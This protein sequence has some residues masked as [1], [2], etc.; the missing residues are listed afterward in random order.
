[1]NLLMISQDFPPDVGG[2]QTYCYELAGCFASMAPRLAVVAPNRPGADDVD[3]SLPFRVYRVHTPNAWLPLMG[4]PPIRSLLHSERFNATF[5]AQ[6]QTVWSARKARKKKMISRIFSAAHGRELLFNPG[7]PGTQL[8]S[9]YNRMRTSLLSRVDH[10]F[11]VSRYTSGLLQN[12]GVEE[13][14]ITVVPNGTNPGQFYPL[15]PRPLRTEMGLT[16]KRVLMTVCRLVP[17]KGVDTVIRAF[18]KVISICPDTELVIIGDGEDRRRL[19]KIAGE[20]GIRESVHFTGW[21]THNKQEMNRF[22]NLADVV[23]MTPRTDPIQ[24]E[25]FGIIYLEAN[26]CGKPVIGSRSGGIS[27]A[28]IDGE[29]GLLVEEDDSGQLAEA[30]VRLLNNPD[31][32]HR[33]GEQ[34]RKRVVNELN[35]NVIAPRIYSKMDQLVKDAAQL[36][37][38]T[39]RQ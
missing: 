9:F 29:T 19:E 28:V 16:G 8:H 37:S 15:D 27:D 13:D 35:W 26:A 18:A 3:R 22:Y 38:K 5:H 7:A 32:A 17:R 10:F 4:I 24:V 23:I 33:L 30:I 6:W 25:A 12:Y 20:S 11:A 36:R 1:M 21:I 39:Q 2:I 31:L 14:R 34:G